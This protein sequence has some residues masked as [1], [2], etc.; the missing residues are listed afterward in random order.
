[1]TRS[2][3]RAYEQAIELDPEQ[4]DFRSAFESYVGLLTNPTGC[5][6]PIVGERSM[7]AILKNRFH[8]YLKRIARRPE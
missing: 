1:M 8:G 7:P 5:C 3:L 6:C 4:G 2:A